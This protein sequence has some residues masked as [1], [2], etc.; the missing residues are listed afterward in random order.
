MMVPMEQH[1]A[2]AAPADPSSADTSASSP[3][4]SGGGLPQSLTGFRIGVTSDRRSEDLISAF[5]R[6]G[7]EVMHAPALRLAPMTESATLQHDTQAVIDAA[8]DFTIITTA[9]G[10][11]RWTEA[12]DAYGLG[13][14]LHE[15]LDGSS[16][17]VR[18]PKARGAVRAAGLDDD[19]AAEDERTATVIDMLLE[20]D[21]AG[22][23]VA[24]QLHGRTD[25]E[26]I[27]RIEAA[28]AR[29]ITV[30]PYAWMKPAED[31]ELLRMIEAVIDR[32]LDIVTF[33][34]APAVDAFL[35]VAHQ[36]GQAEAM[37]EAFRSDVTCAAVGDVT[38]APLLDSGVRPIIPSRWRQGA[39]IRLVGDHLEQHQTL[40]A[41]T[42]HGPVELRGAEVRFPE[43]S[44]EPV[45][46]AP[47]PLALMRALVKAEGAV[48]SRAHLLTVLNQCDSEHALEMWVS[49][50]RKAL[51]VSDVISTV[52]KRGYR[53][54]T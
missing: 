23:T 21:L 2:T 33:T 1:P 47:G 43:V 17:L 44:A 46:L 53:L 8:P 51:P 3:A 50:L 22:R 7:A 29:A 37:L 10:M 19:G 45:R 36:Y 25:H 40:R 11:R 4:P 18:G 5:E 20:H 54:T 9:Y 35:E 15:V 48:L 13:T 32:Q 31:S 30:M 42:R 26:Q 12:A 38:A 49:R 6:R 39:L 16:I 24:F 28:G 14:R 34:A 27:A 41:T 52:V